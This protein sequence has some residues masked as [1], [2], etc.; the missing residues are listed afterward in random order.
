VDRGRLSSLPLVDD[1]TDVTTAH[2][3]DLARPEH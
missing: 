1:R 3:G 2:D